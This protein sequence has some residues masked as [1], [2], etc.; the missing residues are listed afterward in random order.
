MDKLLAKIKRKF[1]YLSSLELGKLLEYI[2]RTRKEIKTED[3]AEAA[4][5][6]NKDDEGSK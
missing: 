4:D 5:R 2:D 3:T 6:D 1:R